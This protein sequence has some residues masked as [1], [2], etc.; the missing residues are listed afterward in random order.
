MTAD[1]ARPGGHVRSGERVR[2]SEGVRA[3]GRVR[4]RGPIRVV[5]LQAAVTAVVAALMLLGGVDA[6]KSALLGGFVVVLP[7]AYF[8]WAAMRHLPEGQA[9]H[10]AL[11]EAGRLIGRWVVK[12]ALTVA[13]L[14]G[15]IVVADAG[16][17]GLFVGLG[18]A[19]LAQ[20]ASPLVG[21]N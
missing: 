20:L 5:G 8:A 11:R 4:P 7:N 18:A 19:L 12:I 6:A 14:V 9:E 21:G 13:M 10:E 16:G 15:A 2:S 1:E 3:G 17:L